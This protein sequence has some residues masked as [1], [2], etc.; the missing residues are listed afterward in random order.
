VKKD[1]II[2]LTMYSKTDKEIIGFKEIF[3][4]LN[5]ILKEINNTKK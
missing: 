2:P 4:I 1:K 3:T 5:N